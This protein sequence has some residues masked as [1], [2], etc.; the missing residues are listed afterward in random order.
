VI[1]PAASQGL[2]ST[3]YL[4]MIQLC[5]PAELDSD[6]DS[7]SETETNKAKSDPKEMEAL[8]RRMQAQ[9]LESDRQGE[10]DRL[11]QRQKE[12]SARRQAKRSAPPRPER[13]APRDAHPDLHDLDFGSI[14]S[15]GK[16][17]PPPIRPDSDDEGYVVSVAFWVL[18][19]L[20]EN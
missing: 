9:K 17:L 2:H 15:K 13:G 20:D 19:V 16:G 6:S 3:R 5:K 14:G 12:E 18:H 11:Q 1:R 8:R 7:D 4:L 10:L